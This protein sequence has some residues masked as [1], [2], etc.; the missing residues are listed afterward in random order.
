MF[1]SKSAIYATTNVARRIDL[2]IEAYVCLIL[3]SQPAVSQN[4]K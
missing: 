1:F 4:V 2:I 3:C